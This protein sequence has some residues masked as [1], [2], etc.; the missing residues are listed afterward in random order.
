[1]RLLIALSIS[2]LAGCST[3][4]SGVTVENRDGPNTGVV[5]QLPAATLE[6]RV[7]FLPTRCDN[8]AAATDLRAA[9]RVASITQRL[10]PD[11]DETYAIDYAK[12]NSALKITEASF[13]KYPSGMIKSINADVDDRSAQ[14]LTSAAGAIVNIA[15]GAAFPSTLIPVDG[16]K[17]KIVKCPRP[18]S[19][20]MEKLQLKRDEIISATQADKTLAESQQQLVKVKKD[21]ADVEDKLK[22]SPKDAALQA[23]VAALKKQSTALEDSLKGKSPSLPKIL[24]DRDDLLKKLTATV[25]LNWTPVIANTCQRIALKW[26]NY[27]PQLIDDQTTAAEINQLKLMTISK[28]PFSAWVC[29]AAVNGGAFDKAQAKV[30][31]VKVAMKGVVYRTPTMARVVVHGDLDGEIDQELSYAVDGDPWMSFP[32]LGT[33]AELVLDNKTFDKNGVKI[34]FAEDGSLTSLE[35]RAESS[36]ERGAAAA[37]DLSGQYVELMTLRAKSAKARE[38][39]ADAAV[40]KQREDEIAAYDAQIALITKRQELELTRT[41]GKDRT[42]IL[43]DVTTKDTLLLQGKID[44]EKKRQELQKLLSEAQ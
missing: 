8:I 43:I 15:K 37:K 26:E 27:Y 9:L 19:E 39:A 30:A 44:Q 14:I 42:Q 12:L 21:L 7:A 34:L 13:I 1:M 41:G 40:K 5:Y 16:G 23:A 32:Q 10:V 28:S 29:V 3:S 6:G 18:L 38:D 31:N 35:F 36:A 17:S 4:L 20:P 25:A 11:V 24:A 33:K 2:L 22:A